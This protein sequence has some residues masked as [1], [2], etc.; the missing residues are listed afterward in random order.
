MA[1][2]VGFGCQGSDKKNVIRNNQEA[3]QRDRTRALAKPSQ[4]FPTRPFTVPTRHH[5]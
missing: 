2:E 5:H 4:D 1:D 3:R